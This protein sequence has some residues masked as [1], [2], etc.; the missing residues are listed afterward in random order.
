MANEQLP[1]ADL[2]KQ[3][4]NSK[5]ESDR[6]GSLLEKK[7]DKKEASK[8]EVIEEAEVV[9]EEQTEEV[10]YSV[11][12]LNSLIKKQIEGSFPI[13]W[14]QAEI[15]NFKAH[16]SGHFY[17]SLKDDKSQINAV[18]FKGLNSKLK[19]RPESGMEVLV[20]GKVTVYEPRGNYQIFCEHMEPVG[21]GA[22]QK[23]FEQLKAKLQK[24]GLFDQ[25]HKKPLPIFPKHIGVVTSP[26]GAAIRDILNV[27][28]RRH[29]AVEVTIIPARVQGEG[30]AEEVARGVELANRVN[31]FDVLIVGRGGGSIEDLWCFNEEIVARAIFA[32]DLPVISAV[33]HEV[34]YTIADFV[35]DYRAPTPSAAAEV[36]VQ[37]VAELKERILTFQSRL[38]QIINFRLSHTL[39]KLHN[40]QSKLVDPKRRLADLNMQCDEL[41]LRLQNAV[42]RNLKEKRLT[43]SVLKE[44]LKSPEA[45]LKYKKDKI[46]SL[47]RSLQKE[48]LNQVKSNKERLKGLMGVMHSLSPLQVVDRGYAIVFKEDKIIK[49][50]KSVQENDQLKIQLSDGTLEVQVKNKQEE[51]WTLKKN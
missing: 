36:V 15:S 35:A 51:S 5:T 44:R 41:V 26:T 27:L 1:F 50:V 7:D 14:V 6:W 3:T 46:I 8:E 40:L 9:V 49:N 37:S 30:A 31:M 18:M 38:A 29:K 32:S 47:S 24:E 23:A 45:L 48:V 20:R 12:D 22:L 39:Q 4:K 21:A 34:D 16:T 43:V 19:F 28:E 17:F 42:N 11:S 2:N 33:G 25:K 13:V 10:I